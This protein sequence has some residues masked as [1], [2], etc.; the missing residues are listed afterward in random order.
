MP[1]NKEIV[2]KIEE[3]SKELDELVDKICSPYTS[4]LDGCI[5]HLQDFSASK[6]NEISMD[7]LNRAMVFISS[8]M[9]GLVNHISKQAVRMS[10]AEMLKDE[11]YYDFYS[12]LTDGTI[13]DKKSQT[14]IATIE[15]AVTVELYKRCYN[16]LKETYQ[17]ADNVF[18]GLKKICNVK[19]QEM[20][21]SIRTN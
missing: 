21:L 3:N 7:E 14:E 8:S 19:T 1:V 18:S 15:N 4:P 2:T 20:Q 11:K 10:V 5:A 13:S 12:R 6:D 17:A 9:Y 16:R